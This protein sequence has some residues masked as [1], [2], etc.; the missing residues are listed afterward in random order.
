MNNYFNTK[1]TSEEYFFKEM[2]TEKELLEELMA[3]VDKCIDLFEAKAGNSNG[4]HLICGISL[5][6]ARNYFLI[7]LSS[8]LDGLAQEGGALL[9]PMLEYIELLQYF[10]EDSARVKQAQE[11]KLPNAGK[12]AK[13]INSSF[14]DLRK[15]LNEEASHSSFKENSIG[16]VVTNSD[17][18]LKNQN[19]SEKNLSTNIQFILIFLYYM[20]AV[21]VNC[22]N[23]Q[24]QGSAEKEAIQLMIIREQRMKK[25]DIVVRNITVK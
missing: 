5:I 14:Q 10:Q 6:K 1:R 9:R 22:L 2:S 19:F 18:L 17:N 23:I 16:H 11:D 7:C 20:A 24:E 21:S 12:R 25:L 8:A 3:I 13:M 4:Y 15:Y